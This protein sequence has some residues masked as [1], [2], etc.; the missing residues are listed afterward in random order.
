M[1]PTWKLAPPRRRTTPT[2]MNNQAFQLFMA[3]VAERVD[4]VEDDKVADDEERDW[5][6]EM[7]KFTENKSFEGDQGVH[8]LEK[9][10]EAIGYKRTGFRFGEPLERMLSD[11]PGMQEA[12]IDWL[13][14]QTV[15]DE[16]F[17]NLHA[18]NQDKDPPHEL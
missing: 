13:W 3:R 15:S 8:N 18:S 14:N 12:C 2:M 6:D 17:E 10:A 16:M 1:S 11:N 7:E 5:Y 9:L 4:K